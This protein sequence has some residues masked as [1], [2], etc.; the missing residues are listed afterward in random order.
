MLSKN[1]SVHRFI[2]PLTV[3]NLNLNLQEQFEWL[4]NLV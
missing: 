4:S 1:K 3:L 2:E